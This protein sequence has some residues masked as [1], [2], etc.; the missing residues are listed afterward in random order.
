[1][2]MYRACVA[3]WLPS[4]TVAAVVTQTQ[5]KTDNDATDY[6]ETD[7][8]EITCIY[9]ECVMLT[10][11]KFSAHVEDMCI[12]CTL[13]CKC[14]SICMLLQKAKLNM[15]TCCS[16][17]CCT[18]AYTVYVAI[19]SCACMLHTCLLLPFFITKL[20]VYRQPDLG[21]FMAR[22]MYSMGP[23]QLWVQH[24]YRRPYLCGFGY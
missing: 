18:Y 2:Y 9:T 17:T 3:Y 8:S 15:N 13:C 1:M 10:R 21:C 12:I 5:E 16:Y 14:I 22:P 23:I 19:C 4:A 6:G 7:L 20:T 11:H 24:M